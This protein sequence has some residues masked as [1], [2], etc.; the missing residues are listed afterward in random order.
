MNKPTIVA[1]VLALSLTP[2]RAESLKLTVAD[3]LDVLQGLKTISSGWQ[4]FAVVDGRNQAITR[5]FM[6]D[7]AVRQAIARDIL[8]LMPV[9]EAYQQAHNEKLCELSGGT[10]KIA[11]G[12]AA[13]KALLDYDRTNRKAL[14]EPAPDLARVDETQLQLDKNPA[15][16]PSVLALL[17]PLTAAPR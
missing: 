16:G 9:D 13:A 10:C 4:D 8:A 1:A 12:T 14:A 2:A 5:P 17:H 3:A 15:L 11:D 7:G 6:L